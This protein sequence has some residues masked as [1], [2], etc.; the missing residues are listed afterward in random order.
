MRR[1]LPTSCKKFTRYRRADRIPESGNATIKI[2][3]LDE[4]WAQ[5]AIDALL[6][7][8]EAAEAARTAGKTAVDPETR[9]EHEDWY[10]QAAAAGIAL[11]A[12]R[13]GRLQ[14]KRH[15]L[16]TRMQDREAGYLRFARDLRV[17]T[18]GPNGPR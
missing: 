7:L 18:T 15:A 4:T 16:A 6:A 9:A 1:I 13:S 3:G 17:R 5:Q 11:N 10:R 14:Q 2:C 8:N 12:G